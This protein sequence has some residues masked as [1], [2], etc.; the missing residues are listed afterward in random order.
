VGSPLF[1]VDLAHQ[2]N[3]EITLSQ[4]LLEPGILYLKR[5]EALDV[6]VIPPSN[7]RTLK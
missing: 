2:L 4:K 1:S 6:W 3:V 5:L 7:Q